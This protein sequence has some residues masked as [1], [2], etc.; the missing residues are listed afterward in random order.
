MHQLLPCSHL[1]RI[2]FSRQLP[3]HLFD[4]L[5]TSLSGDVHRYSFS[6]SGGLST[7]QAPVP[8]PQSRVT[9]ASRSCA[10]PEAQQ[11]GTQR[12]APSLLP[13]LD[14]GS[15][16]ASLAMLPTTLLGLFPSSQ[17]LNAGAPHAPGGHLLGDPNQLQSLK[18]PTPAPDPAPQHNSC[19]QLSLNLTVGCGVSTMVK[20][21]AAGVQ[22]RLPEFT[23]GA[24]AH[25]GPGLVQMSCTRWQKW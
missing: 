9:R 3:L 4:S 15:P 2:L 21:V 7:L 1:L 10:S 8:S 18:S 12:Q 20:S 23:P 13:S 11:P 19:P 5:G 14:L 6:F 22:D 16:S 24:A 17:R 25:T